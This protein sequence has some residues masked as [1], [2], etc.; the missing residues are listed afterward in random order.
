[1]VDFGPP[2]AEKLIF[3]TKHRHLWLT[4]HP[5]IYCL[6]TFWLKCTKSRLFYSLVKIWE[7]VCAFWLTVPKCTYCP[8]EA[9]TAAT[10]NCCN[11]SWTNLNFTLSTQIWIKVLVAEPFNTVLLQ[12]L[13]QLF[14]DSIY[15][16]EQK[17]NMCILF[18]MHD[19]LDSVHL[20]QNLYI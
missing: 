7:N 11:I 12:Q 18:L 10:L 6:C 19:H 17:T 20:E 15:I 3:Q 9:V 16:K 14:T 2:G 5:N 1:M 13:W 8:W 4:V